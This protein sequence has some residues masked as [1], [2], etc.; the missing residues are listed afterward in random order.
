MVAGS[1]IVVV[2][3]GP[4]AVRD[5]LDRAL[6]NLG[7]IEVL[8]CVYRSHWLDP[9]RERLQRTLR[10]ARRRSFGRVAIGRFDR[11]GLTFV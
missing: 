10:S 7:F 2:D 8:P 6:R 4:S 3:I 1:W 5:R 9:K 11:K